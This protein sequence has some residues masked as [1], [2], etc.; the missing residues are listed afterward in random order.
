VT[1]LPVSAIKGALHAVAVKGIG[2]GAD[3]KAVAKTIGSDISDDAWQ[4]AIEE[5]LK[6]AALIK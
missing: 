6:E 3:E 2:A 5:T 1:K 4:L